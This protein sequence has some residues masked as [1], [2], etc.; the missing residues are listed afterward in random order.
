MLTLIWIGLGVLLDRVWHPRTRLLEP[1][2]Q[3]AGHRRSQGALTDR[4]SDREW[5][6]MCPGLYVSSGLL[7]FLIGPIRKSD[8]CPYCSFH[9][10]SYPAVSQVSAEPQSTSE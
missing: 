3:V 1:I 4:L 7:Y 9:E 8:Q 6:R 10:C 2:Q 5:L